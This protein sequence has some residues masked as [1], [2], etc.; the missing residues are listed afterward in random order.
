MSKIFNKIRNLILIHISNEE[1]F[2]IFQNDLQTLDLLI[3][4]QI[5]I[6][7]NHIIEKIILK[8]KY[9][10]FYLFD[11]IEDRLKK[12]VLEFMII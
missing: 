3:E 11:R 6:L 4:E 5:L 8:G 1:L 9:H 12:L 2:N 7:T 10:V